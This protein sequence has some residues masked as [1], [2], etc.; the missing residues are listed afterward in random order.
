MHHL[1]GAMSDS[2]ENLFVILI[3][4]EVC[5]FSVVKF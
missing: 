1:R 2:D 3:D 4:T 5:L